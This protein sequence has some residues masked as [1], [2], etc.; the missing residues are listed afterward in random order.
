MRVGLLLLLLLLVPLS[1]SCFSSFSAN[2][3][4]LT[5]SKYDKH[6]QDAAIFLPVGWDWRLLKAQIY[7]E[8]GF[9]PHAVSPVGAKGL[10]QF[11]PKTW[12]E[13]GEGSVYC[14]EC[15]I[16]ASAVYLS[17]LYRIWSSP[18]PFIDRVLITTASYNAG[19]GS[20]IKAQRFCGMATLYKDIIKCLPDVTGHHSKE[21]IDYNKKILRF[22]SVLI[23][24]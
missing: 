8:S 12:E 13:V 5:S 18:R 2:A 22:Y 16:R 17:R 24:E 7:A 23:I 6:F 14:E 1:A 3:G 21:T 10:G 9:D 4:S 19:A 20:L 15:S 11:M